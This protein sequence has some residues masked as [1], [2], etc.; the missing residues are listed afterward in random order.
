MRSRFRL[1]SERARGM[2]RFYFCNRFWWWT[3]TTHGRATPSIRSPGTTTAPLERKRKKDLTL[4]CARGTQGTTGTRQSTNTLSVLFFLNTSVHQHSRQHQR[5]D[6][7]D[8]PLSRDGT[9]KPWTS[10]TN[11]HGA[12]GAEY[13]PHLGCLFFV[14]LWY[15]RH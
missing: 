7:M 12:K 14:P 5:R 13:C 4:M 11:H 3:K 1:C 15:S 10:E 6:R 8:S 9:V 2:P